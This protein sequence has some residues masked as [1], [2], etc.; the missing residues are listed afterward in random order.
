MPCKQAFLEFALVE[1]IIEHFFSIHIRFLTYNY[2]LSLKHGLLC[3]WRSCSGEVMCHPPG[4]RAAPPWP[5][6][7]L[8]QRLGPS[9]L[10]RVHRQIM[11]WVSALLLKQI[12]RVILSGGEMEGSKRFA[13]ANWAWISAHGTLLRSW[14][15]N[16]V[17]RGCRNWYVY[18]CQST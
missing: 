3:L 17:P 18:T 2:P 13:R 15:R 10:E 1:H 5:C 14:S 8:R 16:Q 6:G 11:M 7:F 12:C 4:R 9:S